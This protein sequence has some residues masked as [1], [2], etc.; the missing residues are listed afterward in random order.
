VFFWSLQRFIK[1]MYIRRYP[2]TPTVFF[3]LIYFI[4]RKVVL[5][6]GISVIK[7][8]RLRCIGTVGHRRPESIILCLFIQYLSSS[9]A[10]SCERSSQK[11]SVFSVPARPSS[12]LQGNN[13]CLSLS[14]PVNRQM[15]HSPHSV[16]TC[17][18]TSLVLFMSF[19][20]SFTRCVEKNVFPSNSLKD[21]RAVR[22]YNLCL[23]FCQTFYVT[24][25]VFRIRFARIQILSSEFQILK[26]N[27]D[28]D[29]IF[30][31]SPIYQL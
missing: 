3:L 13:I 5:F 16:T 17:T 9:Y 19:F 21:V 12:P 6:F 14:V 27:D 18:R 11:I 22:Y 26:K 30:P 8:F 15:V 4:F 24:L 10:S 29:R 25:R 7:K 2:Y 20:V 1:N 31:F 23:I 28:P